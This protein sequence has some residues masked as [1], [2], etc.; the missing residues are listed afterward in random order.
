GNLRQTSTQLA[1][2]LPTAKVIRNP[3]NV[4]YDTNPA[5]PEG[6]TL[7]L[8]CV[9][10]LDPGNKG[11]DLLLHALAGEQWR[12]RDFHL[13]LFGDGPHAQSILALRDY[14][15]LQDTVSHGGFSGDVESI[16]ANHHALALTSRF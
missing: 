7:R 12:Q 1:D 14:L 15:G 6:Q 4:S 5:W 8:A 13:T 9:G 10:R 11:Q 3:F 16:W 2:P